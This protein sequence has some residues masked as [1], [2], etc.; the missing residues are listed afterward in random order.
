[1]TNLDSVYLS[2]EPY[3]LLTTFRL[4]GRPVATPVW[5]VE[6][7]DGLLVTTSGASG[8]VKRIRKNTSVQ[9]APCDARG[10]VPEGAATIIGTARVLEDAES[11]GVIDA[12]LERKY[13]L[14]YKAIRAAGKVRRSITE[15]VVVRIVPEA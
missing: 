13:G 12:A 3:V 4:S 10:R 2:S 1:M 11:R 7:L 5:V 9:L 6:G 8:K 14:R 15:S